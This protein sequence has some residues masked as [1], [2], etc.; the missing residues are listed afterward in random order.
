MATHRFE[1]TPT[2]LDV[3]FIRSTTSFVFIKKQTPY[4]R[5]AFNAGFVVSIF[6]PQKT[7]LVAS[8][9]CRRNNQYK[10][11]GRAQLRTCKQR[12]WGRDRALMRRVLSAG[13]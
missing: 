9:H 11:C 7:R 5:L 6:L 12:L 4:K 1:S 10:I 2:I 13:N 3:L 8:N